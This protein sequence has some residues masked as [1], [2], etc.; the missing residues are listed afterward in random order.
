MFKISSFLSLFHH[1]YYL[2]CNTTLQKRVG[3]FKLVFVFLVY[4]NTW[5]FK[6]NLWNSTYYTN[7]IIFLRNCNSRDTKFYAHLLPN[8]NHYCRL[9]NKIDLFVEAL[10]RSLPLV[11]GLGHDPL[12]TNH[13]LEFRSYCLAL[14][15]PSP[16]FCAAWWVVE[17]QTLFLCYYVYR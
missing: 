1:N 8:Q 11:W 6:K 5:N 17:F 15:P 16:I 9:I 13:P 2:T 12:V 14:L 3:Q 7:S 4:K 10:P